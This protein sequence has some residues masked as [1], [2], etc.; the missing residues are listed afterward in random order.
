[1]PSAF[2]GVVPGS[3]PGSGPGLWLPKRRQSAERNVS[4]S[5]TPEW[6][7]WGMMAHHG[8][9]RTRAGASEVWGVGR[10]K[11]PG[12][13]KVEQPTAVHAESTTQRAA[14]SVHRSETPG[15]GESVAPTR[16]LTS[17]VGRSWSLWRLQ[18][19]EE[20]MACAPLQP[21]LLRIHPHRVG[22]CVRCERAAVAL[23]CLTGGSLGWLTLR[24][25]PRPTLRG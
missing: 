13:E 5:C 11:K 23:L 16:S 7:R 15:S 12:A 10:G 22:G 4:P 19:G 2:P 20:G 18:T 1:M 25:A 14:P 17:P 8:E 21:P 3:S 6:E 9:G 24:S